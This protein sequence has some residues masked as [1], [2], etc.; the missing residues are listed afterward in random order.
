M[1]EALKC[2]T[3]GGPV[4][5]RA[6]ESLTI[7][8]YCNGALKIARPE[9]GAAAVEVDPTIPGETIDRIKDLI[10][11]GRRADAVAL[12][13][14]AARCEPAAA[15]AAIETYVR[16]AVAD[17]IFAGTLNAGGVVLYVAALAFVA[18]GVVAFVRDLLPTIACVVLVGFGAINLLV[19]TRAA[20]KTLRYLAATRGQATI[21]RHAL[22]G[23]HG[24]VS[25][26]L[27]LIDVREPSGATFQ[28]E[29]AFPASKTGAEKVRVGRRFHV[30]YFPRDPKSVVFDGN[31]DD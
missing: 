26:F 25:S 21:L 4:R 27:M 6:G 13:R 24:N 10:V 9:S 22:I 23:K 17:T 28:T 29:I 20:L 31:L 1:I 8:L 14:D 5:V 18:A 19:L 16:S 15:E 2:P 12:Y 7:C 30:K 3:C 11:R